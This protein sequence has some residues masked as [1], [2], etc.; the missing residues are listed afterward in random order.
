VTT[1]AYVEV[2]LDWVTD[3]GWKRL[4]GWAGKGLYCY[5]W[6]IIGDA[7][8]ITRELVLDG[9]E[10]PTG[11]R[12]ESCAYFESKSPGCIVSMPP[13]LYGRPN[14]KVIYQFIW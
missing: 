8:R 4:E 6:S 2:A 3:R 10:G 12:G 11:N 14:L 5:K 1:S 7:R 9:N 13:K